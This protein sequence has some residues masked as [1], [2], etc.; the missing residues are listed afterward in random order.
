ML[1]LLQAVGTAE[2]SQLSEYRVKAAFVFNFAKFIEWPPE[3]FSDD[4]SQLVI[5]ILGENPFGT[6]LDQTIQNKTINNHP[7]AIKQMRSLKEVTNCH[8]L[9][10][11][12]S[13]TARLPEILRTVRDKS[14]LT[15]GESEGF[16]QAGGMI[17]FTWEGK[18]IRFQINADAAKQAKLKISS[19][20]LSLAIRPAQ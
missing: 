6:D 17:N 19:K 11:S 9:F 4:T 12:S 2:E 5:G 1:A 14:I 15:V 18:K 20:L 10:I 16:I 13:E 8:I 3:S 7:L